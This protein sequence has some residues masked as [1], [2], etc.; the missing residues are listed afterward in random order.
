L[1]LADR[2]ARSMIGYWHYNVVGLSVCDAVYC[3]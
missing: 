1:I 2:I 3:G